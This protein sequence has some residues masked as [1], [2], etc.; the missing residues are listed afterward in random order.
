ME[1]VLIVEMPA[2]R[3]APA[4]EGISWASSLHV[5]AK[6]RVQPAL[7][8]MGPA[9]VSAAFASAERPVGARR[10]PGSVQVSARALVEHLG[11]PQSKF[12]EAKESAENFGGRLTP[13]LVG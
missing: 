4:I 2:P 13:F 8:G 5:R 7:R 6:H 12:V 10:V 3:A 1:V 9:R 11:C